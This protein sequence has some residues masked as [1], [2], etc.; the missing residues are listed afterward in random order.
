MDS[1]TFKKKKERQKSKKKRQNEKKKQ[2]MTKRHQGEV[3]L[4][5]SVISV[6]GVMYP[7]VLKKIINKTH[8]TF[9]N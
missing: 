8:R 2:G 5:L 6:A 4:R 3:V 1:Y 7:Y 9:S